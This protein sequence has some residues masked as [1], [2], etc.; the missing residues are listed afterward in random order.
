MTDDNPAVRQLRT[1]LV[2]IDLG[3][4]PHLDP[5]R[6]M[7]AG[8]RRRRWRLMTVSAGSAVVLCGLVLGGSLLRQGSSQP[9]APP[10]VSESSS[11]APSVSPSFSSGLASPDSSGEPAKGCGPDPDAS[12]TFTINPD[13]PFPAD[14]AIVGKDQRLRVVNATNAFNQP[15]A[16]ITLDFAGLPPRTVRVGEATTYNMPFG[17]YLAPGQHQLQVSGYGDSVVI[18]WLK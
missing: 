1:L 3:A 6:I 17:S 18:I 10:G 13:G 12:V 8:L 7:R 9:V 2:D 4:G 5:K 14:C 16:A 15:G 11:P